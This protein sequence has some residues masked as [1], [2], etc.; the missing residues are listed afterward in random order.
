MKALTVKQPWANAIIRLG[1]DV[2]NRSRPTSYRG[3]LFIHAGLTY[4]QEGIDFL[5]ARGQWPTEGANV[6]GKVIGTVGVVDCH[7]AD[8]CYDGVEHCSEWAM[9]DNYHWVLTKP[10]P[11]EHPFP[12]KGKLGIWNIEVPA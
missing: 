11:L 10:K 5:R 1:K 12:A 3:P 4:S 7:H 6:T 2:E 9:P 8:D